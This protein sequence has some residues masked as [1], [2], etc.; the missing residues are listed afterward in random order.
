MH[1]Y[2]RAASLENF[3][4]IYTKSYRLNLNL[5]IEKNKISQ[6]I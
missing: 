1:A 4:R 3:K 5:L 2:D 6:K